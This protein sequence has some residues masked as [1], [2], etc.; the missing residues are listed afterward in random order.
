MV[1]CTEGVF[2]HEY[3]YKNIADII[4][5]LLVILKYK[6]VISGSACVYVNNKEICVEEDS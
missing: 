4:N 3:F 1:V 5:L 6:S 2:Q